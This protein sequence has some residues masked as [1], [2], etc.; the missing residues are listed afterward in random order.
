M[1]DIAF[2][3]RDYSL[4]SA[5]ASG[6]VDVLMIDNY[7][8]FTFNLVQYVEELGARVTVVR[9][10]ALSVA[11]VIAL[12]PRRVI[13][14][15]GPGTPADAGISCDL[16]RALAGVV[17][18]LGVCLGLQAMFEVFGGRVS[19]AGEVVHGKASRMAHD[20]EGVFKG[21]P[22][23]LRAVRY[24]SLAGEEATLP[25]ALLVTCR[26]IPAA[27]GGENAAFET[28]QGV[29]H[30]SFTVEGVQFHPESV[31]T[32]HGHAMI[33]NFLDWRGGTWAEQQ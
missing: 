1:A 8:S 5:L 33:A 11:E 19:E 7:D 24:H 28:I 4:A 31:L 13:I 3:A 20:G 9:N 26:T 18:V 14:S 30:A 21:L 10:D 12:R 23:P 17:P 22:S 15:P 32:E 2:M 25:P 16:I 6:G 29:R 27:A